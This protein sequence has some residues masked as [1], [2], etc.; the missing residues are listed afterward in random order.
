MRNSIK[1][2]GLVSSMALISACSSTPTLTS[3]AK[4]VYLNTNIGF[5]QDNYSYAQSNIS[6]EVTNELIE[7]IT[8]RAAKE[9]IRVKPVYTHMEIEGSD[10]ILA[11]DI[12]DMPDPSNINYV[13]SKN[14]APELGIATV[15]I[16]KSSGRTF[17]S[18]AH[19]SGKL[20]NG[21]A[22]WNGHGATSGS[23]SGTSGANMCKEMRRCARKISGKVIS[24]LTEETNL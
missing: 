23:T 24:W 9:N 15:F 17:H 1:V 7:T 19:C 13:G 4:V 21:S 2:I 8:K 22:S 14:I 6:C 12:T 20:S 11:L 5:N 10:N 3:D 16:D 18:N